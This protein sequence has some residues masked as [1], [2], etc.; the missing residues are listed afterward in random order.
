[1]RLVPLNID[2]IV[3]GQPL[4][5]SLRDAQGKLLAQ[6]GYTIPS[7]A[8]LLTMLSK[9][10]EL[11]I[12]IVESEAQHKAYLAKLYDLTREQRNLGQIA[13]TTIERGTLNTGG[14]P[15]IDGPADWLDLQANA[16]ILLKDGK[17]SSFVERLR[18]FQFVLHQ[19]SLSNP[20]GTLFALFYLASAEVKMYSA[21]HAMLV[22][23]A[24][25]LAAREVLKWSPQESETLGLA[26]LSMN[27]SMTELQDEL[28][29]QTDPLNQAQS[30][31]INT[32]RALSAHMLE[33]LGV[34][35]AVWIEA[36]LNHHS[37]PP[38]PLSGRSVAGRIARLIH[39]ADRFVASLSPR[40]SRVPFSPAAAMQACYFDENKQV[41][42]AGAA[43]IKAV[44]IYS[45]G[46]FVK[47]TSNEIAIVVR[48]GFNS[49]TPRVAVLVN[50]D[51]VPT[52]EPMI[53]DTSLRE[54]RIVSSIPSRDMKV[55]I[56][57]ERMLKLTV[58]TSQDRA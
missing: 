30:T 2:S 32:H 44:G 47:L 7:K 9:G 15:L 22:S 54:Y 20:D 11:Y 52:V 3:T 42:E 55:K 24:C 34:T 27:I 41:D 10:F 49:A 13:K 39:C 58:P 36:V 1:M 38:G 35:D 31:L 19:H 33:Q 23:V 40:A 12:D 26:A 46:S 29:Q 50:R 6:K 21:T 48:R 45:P 14:R 37:T 18:E 53:R 51:G 57:L 4:P 16:N 8:E 56:N 5:F 43:L 25:N 28:A 17:S